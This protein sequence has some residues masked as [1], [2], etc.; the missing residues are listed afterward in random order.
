MFLKTLQFS[1][2]GRSPSS[3]LYLKQTA[4]CFLVSTSLTVKLL[5]VIQRVSLVKASL[6]VF[7]KRVAAE[8]AHGADSVHPSAEAAGGFTGNVT[9]NVLQVSGREKLPDLCCIQAAGG[10]A[11]ARCCLLFFCSHKFLLFGVCGQTCL[12]RDGLL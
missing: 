4:D 9:A 12:I 10:G 8:G 5:L 2:S 6:T 7:A 1:G 3:T 11:T